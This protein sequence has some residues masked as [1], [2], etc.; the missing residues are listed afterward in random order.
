MNFTHSNT[1]ESLA[2]IFPLLLIITLLS[3]CTNNVTDDNSDEETIFSGKEGSIVLNNSGSNAFVVTEVMGEGIEADTDNNNVAITLSLGGRYTFKNDAGASSHP[4]DFRD[5]DG[6]KLLGQSNS[7][8]EFAEDEDVNVARSGD[9]I[10][11][12][13]TESLANKIADYICSFHPSM[14]GGIIVEQWK[15]I[16]GD[17]YSSFIRW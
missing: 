15:Y 6:N 14:N 5:A 8:G 4:L 3:A 13:L 17:V 11:F 7:E 1:I 10:T 12:T 9:N 2:I 16:S